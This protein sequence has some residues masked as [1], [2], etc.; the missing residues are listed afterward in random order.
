M[1]QL[2]H[3]PFDCTSA[4]A[5]VAAYVPPLITRLPL[6]L[7]AM[8]AINVPLTAEP[9]MLPLTVNVALLMT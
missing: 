6:L 8:P 7:F 3:V 2:P 4:S 1:L 5:T 9:E